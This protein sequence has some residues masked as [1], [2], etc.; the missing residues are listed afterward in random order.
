MQKIDTSS[1]TIGQKNEGIKLE[2]IEQSGTLKEV[3]AGAVRRYERAKQG[4]RVEPA[5]LELQH[6][7]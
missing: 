1:S 4:R 3:I 7:H 6:A 5:P 2:I